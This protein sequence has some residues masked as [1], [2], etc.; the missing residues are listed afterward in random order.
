MCAS[1]TPSSASLSSSK[2]DAISGKTNK[3]LF[4]INSLIRFSILLSILSLHIF[5]MTFSL[6]ESKTFESAM[7]SFI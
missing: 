7:K 3:R 1:T 5:R 6:S 2:N 4:S